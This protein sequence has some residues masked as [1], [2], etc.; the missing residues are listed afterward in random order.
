MKKYTLAVLCGI[1]ILSAVI[2][3][4]LKYTIHS[5][6]ITKLLGDSNIYRKNDIIIKVYEFECESGVGGITFDVGY[7]GDNLDVYDVT[8]DNDFNAVY[9]DNYVGKLTVGVTEKDA[10]ET[11]DT[12][13][14]VKIAVGF[15]TLYMLDASYISFSYDVKSFVDGKIKKSKDYNIS[16][17]LYIYDDVNDTEYE[18]YVRDIIGIDLSDTDIDTE[19]ETDTNSETENDTETETDTNSETE[20][21]TETKTDTD[22]SEPMKYLCGD[23]DFDGIITSADALYVLR[24]SVELEYFTPVQNRLGD[25]DGDGEITSADSLEILRYSV[26]LISS[27]EAGEIILI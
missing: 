14:S 23:V 15:K 12:N 21:D 17:S 13:K 5:S 8:A 6:E 26:G 2:L 22:T 4:S 24:N 25:V 7:D 19:T 9:R 11:A 27:S 10:A 18:E 1:L 16:E 20:N 3:P